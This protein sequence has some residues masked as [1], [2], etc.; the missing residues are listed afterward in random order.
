MENAKAGERNSRR[1][2]KDDGYRRRA[3]A[4]ELSNS[5]SREVVRHCLRYLLQKVDSEVQ[6][7]VQGKREKEASTL[8][9]AE[10]A[11][12]FDQES[13][14]FEGS[15]QS[16]GNRRAEG[17]KWADGA[18]D[19]IKEKGSKEEQSLVE[20]RMVVSGPMRRTQA[21]D[22]QHRHREHRE[23]IDEPSRDESRYVTQDGGESAGRSQSGP[24][25]PD[26]R[27][28]DYRR[29]TTNRTELASAGKRA[30]LPD[31][32]TPVPEVRAADRAAVELDGVLDSSVLV[33]RGYSPA[34][35]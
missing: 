26:L 27:A 3:A 28:T 25:L 4:V 17:R 31:Q 6:S 20:K 9:A 24:P 12:G 35:K 30:A 23:S 5:V 19:L 22:F 15:N 18:V 10:A 2:T 32:V 34:G 8:A 11:Y 33:S 29:E 21:A 14:G 1:I 16:R 13:A 7:R